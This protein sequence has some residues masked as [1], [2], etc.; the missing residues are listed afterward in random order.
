MSEL[1]DN[2]LNV[3]RILNEKQSKQLKHLALEQNLQLSLLSKVQQ[4]FQKVDVIL[5]KATKTGI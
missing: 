5:E 4:E 3:F 2:Q 1:L